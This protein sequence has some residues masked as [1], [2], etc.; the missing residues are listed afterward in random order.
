MRMASWVRTGLALLGLTVVG[1]SA[2]DS[3]AQPP[4]YFDSSLFAVTLETPDGDPLRVYWHRGQRFVLGDAGDRYNVRVSNYS[5]ERVEAVVSVD[6]RD[7]VSGDSGDY[8]RHRGYLVPAHGSVLIEGFRQSLDQV[9]AFRFTDPS[10]SYAARMGSPE[11]VGV[12]GVAVFSERPEPVVRRRWRPPPPPM[13]DRDDDR[14]RASGAPEPRH[15]APKAGAADA[16]PS[17]KSAPAPSASRSESARPR[18]YRYDY[19]YRDDDYD[20]WSG[21]RNNLGTRYGESTYSP[22]GTTRFVRDNPTVPA[23]ILRVRYDDAAGL[24]ARGIRV[25]PVDAEPAAYYDDPQPFPALRFAP[26]PP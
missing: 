6:G 1:L 8:V 23:S 25:W 17:T 11:N 24:A 3:D 5:S 21:Q 22:V 16:S 14:A 2:A 19:D 4:R 15:A 13:V 18:A 20:R 7:A 10:D 9:A 26:P 12:V